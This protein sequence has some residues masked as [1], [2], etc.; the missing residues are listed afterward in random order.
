[1]AARI[2]HIAVK[3]DDL[4]QVEKFYE[5]V[6]GFT[7]KG[8]SRSEDR[9]RAT[10]NNGDMDLIF[11]KY[12]SED[13]EMA[14]AVGEGPSVPHCAIVVDDMDEYVEKINNFGCEILTPGRRSI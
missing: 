12:D 6:F 1:M 10:L 8:R 4:D 11:L 5:T 9:N 14:K 3:V 2:D 7:S 13:V